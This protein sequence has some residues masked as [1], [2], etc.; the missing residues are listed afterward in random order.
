[1]SEEEAEHYIGERCFLTG[2]PRRIGVELEWLLRSPHDRAAPLDW[3]RS[4]RAVAHLTENGALPGGGRITREPGGQLELSS[5]PADSLAACVAD[6]AAD[7]VAIECALADRGLLVDG[8]ALDACRPPVLVLDEPRYR[9]MRSYYD[10]GDMGLT[11]MCATASVQ[12]NLDAGEPS[13]VLGY[14]RRWELAH[15][16]GPVLIA[17]FAN[18]PMLKDR[19]TGWKSTR[20]AIWAR[21]DP[22]RTRPVPEG[23][24]P[25]H[26]WARYALDARLLCLRREEHEPWDAPPELTFRAWLRGECAERHPTADDLDYHL[27]TLFP[28][29]RPRGWLELRMIDAQ[30]E[31]DWVVPL[32]LCAMLFDDPQATVAAWEATEALTGG[33]PRP[34]WR[35]WLRAARTGLDEPDLAEAARACFAAATEALARTDVPESL[36]V[37]LAEFADRY[38]ERGRCPADDQL[39]AHQEIPT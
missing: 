2:R 18:S 29:V 31:H 12:V 17:A 15:R 27:G 7:M 21:I 26:A 34:P 22:G 39:P 25:R 38:V 28:P 3:E 16:L 9:A 24:D 23:E 6:T 20:Q 30:N 1:M 5:R 10:H 13:G 11:L 14:R 8:G 32:A 36:R 4:K 37:A 19:P 35:T 33:E